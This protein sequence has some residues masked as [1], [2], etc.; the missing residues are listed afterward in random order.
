MQD[1]PTLR[2]G[3]DLL[4][5]MEAQSNL[6]AGPTP[7]LTT[8]FLSRLEISTPTDPG[9]S[10]DD[11]GPS[12]GHYQ[13]TSGSMTINS[14]IR[15]WDCIGTT[16]MACKLIA[17]AIKTCRVARHVCFEQNINTSSYLADVYL[18]RLIDRL[19]D[20]WAETGVSFFFFIFIFIFIFLLMTVPNK[21][22]T[23][24][25]TAVTPMDV[26]INLRPQAPAPPS[27]PPVP[28]SSPP[29]STIV[30]SS[31][32]SLQDAGLVGA[33]D[34]T[35]T[36]E[37]LTTGIKLTKLKSLHVSVSIHISRPR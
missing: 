16:T 23:Q 24:S 9:L 1:F 27:P 7:S 10:E 6:R 18:S 11:M 37:S 29:V 14:V 5:A 19:S 36:G 21:L 4:N 26:D 8:N 28:P 13:Y 34:A 30:D 33:G 3:I 22:T 31:A 32:P 25:G 15:S 12:W 2:S 35:A 20:V 17:A